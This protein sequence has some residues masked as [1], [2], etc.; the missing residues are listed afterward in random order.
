MSNLTKVVWLYMRS[1][2]GCGQL[3]PVV[4]SPTPATDILRD[5]CMGGLG[6]RVFYSEGPYILPL[7]ASGDPNTAYFPLSWPSNQ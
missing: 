5:L 1:L 3:F 4:P 6:V 2:S 7:G